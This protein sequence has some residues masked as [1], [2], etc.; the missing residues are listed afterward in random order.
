M[1]ISTL[2]PL[3]LYIHIPWCVKKC[4]YCDFNSHVANNLNRDI[5]N[6]YINALITDLEY[7][8]P[9]IWGRMINTIFIGGGTPSIMDANYIINLLDQIRSRVHL[10]PFAEI[11]IEANPESLSLAKIK[12]YANNAGINRISIGVQSFNPQQL[13][14]LSR[15]HDCNTAIQSIEYA[16]EHIQNVNIDLMYGLPNQTCQDLELE[17]NLIKQFPINH[18][19]YYNLTIEQNTVFATYTPKGMPNNDLCFEMQEI[20]VNNLL[21]L[22]F[23]R[24]E[25]SAFARQDKQHNN[26]QT[27][28][29][30]QESNVLDRACAI[31]YNMQLCDNGR[32]HEDYTYLDHRCLHNLNY[33]Q[34]GDYLGI[35]AGAHSKISFQDKIVRMAKIK[36]P[37][38]YIKAINSLPS[39]NN[40]IYDTCNNYIN[41]DNLPHNNVANCLLNN[42]NHAIEITLYDKN[43]NTASL[44]LEFFMNAFRLINGVELQLFTARTGL[45]IEHIL[46]SLNRL[47]KNKLISIDKQIIKP[48]ALGINFL[49]DIL[50]EFIGTK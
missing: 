6:E 13:T 7:H 39:Y 35:G 20:I 46:S 25:I 34:F 3:S 15:A 42:K 40:I 2:P 37:S 23:E 38:G 27:Q 24:Y 14:N 5:Q 45:P 44:P 19:S 9:I 33:W 21:D 8:L 12:E 16:T 10:S 32:S 43:N 26:D 31:D 36:Q 47:S 28:Y 50:L 22:Q 11:T 18:L 29:S 17:F 4:P 1:K 49:N 30:R 48:T 41:N